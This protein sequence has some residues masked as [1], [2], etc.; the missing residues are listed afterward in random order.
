MTKFEDN[1]S[2]YLT[3][4]EQAG[5]P[6]N[7]SAGNQ[8]LFIRTSDHL[9]CRV[10]SAGTVVPIGSGIADQGAFTYLDATDAA[11]PANPS[12]GS[13]RVY[14]K[15]GGLYYRDSTGAEVGPLAAGGGGGGG[16]LAIVSYI[17]GGD[18]NYNATGTVTDVD[19]TNLV[20]TFTAPASGN[21]LIRFNAI[22]NGSSGRGYNQPREGS[23]NLGYKILASPNGYLFSSTAHLVTGLSAGSHT[24]KWGFIV[25]IGGYSIYYGPTYGPLVIEVWTSP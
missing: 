22:S 19:A 6:A 20:V 21:V 10:N 12:A 23:T 3:A 9:L 24:I 17:P 11:A 15:T 5:A 16:L 7:P 2:P 18:G 14:S 8:K 1:L 13:H 25:T 4:V